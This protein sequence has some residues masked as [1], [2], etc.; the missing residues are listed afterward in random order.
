MNAEFPLSTF[1]FPPPLLIKFLRT[2]RHTYS[3]FYFHAIAHF[4]SYGYVLFPASC[5]KLTTTFSFIA[6]AVN[7]YFENEDPECKFFFMCAFTRKRAK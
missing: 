4:K 6:T 7:V 2:L 1:S 3:T 5:S